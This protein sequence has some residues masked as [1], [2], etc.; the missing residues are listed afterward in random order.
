M[1]GRAGDMDRF[2]FYM[3]IKETLSLWSCGG[4]SVIKRV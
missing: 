2:L 3:G 4:G 1:E